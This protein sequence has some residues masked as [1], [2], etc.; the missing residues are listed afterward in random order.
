V[1]APLVRGHHVCSQG[2]R[3][4]LRTHVWTS[5]GAKNRGLGSRFTIASTHSMKPLALAREVMVRV[6]DEFLNEQIEFLP[7]FN[8]FTEVLLDES[9]AAIRA[10][11]YRFFTV[12]HDRGEDIET[13]IEMGNNI[14]AEI[15]IEEFRRWLKLE[16]DVYV[17]TLTD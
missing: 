2:A 8:R 9:P 1:A 10:D 11:R 12:V 13:L 16:R 17:A 14:E 3:R 4:P 7:F 5:F 6:I 15:R